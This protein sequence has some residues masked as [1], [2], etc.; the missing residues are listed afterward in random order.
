MASRLLT[1]LAVLA[2]LGGGAAAQAPPEPV[3]PAIAAGAGA[4]V[5]GFEP[6]VHPYGPGHRGVALRAAAGEDARAAMSGTVTFAGVVARVGWVTVH[7]GG[8]LDTTYGPLDPRAVVRGE[9]VERGQVLGRLA[10]GARHL[11][12]GARLHG[13][14]IDPLLLLGAWE[15]HLVDERAHR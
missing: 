8:G 5:R 3:A 1:A 10:A 12:W 2:L 14:Y 13:A 11:H 15:V 9:T 4:V 7:H 6:P